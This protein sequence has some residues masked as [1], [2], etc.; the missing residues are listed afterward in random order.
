MRVPA[1]VVAFA[2]V[3]DF[4]SPHAP[5]L[6]HFGKY[7]LHC[8]LP[9]KRLQRLGLLRDQGREIVPPRVWGRQSEK[10]HIPA[11]ALVLFNGRVQLP[12]PLF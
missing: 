10:Q 11:P 6:A 7:R 9:E 5:Q 3:G 8:P 1:V 12:P 2:P 4:K